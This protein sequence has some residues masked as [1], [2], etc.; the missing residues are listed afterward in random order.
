MIIN[1]FLC[2]TFSIVMEST[3]QVY[4]VT[5]DYASSADLGVNMS[6]V[7]SA[8]PWTSTGNQTKTI[9][10]QGLN[11][12]QV[13]AAKYVG[14]NGFISTTNEHISCTDSLPF[15]RELFIGKEI[16]EV[17]P[18]SVSSFN[19]IWNFAHFLQSRVKHW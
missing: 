16:D 9:F 13:Q 12:S 2:T 1:V 6:L 14:V 5:K 19:S 4:L 15:I 17:I 11:C 18:K 10:Y 7:I 3:N 8:L